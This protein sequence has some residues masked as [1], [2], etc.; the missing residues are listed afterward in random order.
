ME[1]NPADA[2]RR[3]FEPD[4]PDAPPRIPPIEIPPD[5][6]E[7]DVLEQHQP[8]GIDEDDDD[9]REL[10]PDVPEADALDQLRSVT[11]DDEFDDEV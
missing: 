1:R 11:F 3:A 7:A 5:T 9:V 8:V 10:P 2:P 6:P 4:E